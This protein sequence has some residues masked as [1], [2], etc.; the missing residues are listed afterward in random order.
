MLEQVPGLPAFVMFEMQ[1]D[2]GMI[3]KTPARDTLFKVI[4]VVEPE[5]KGLGLPP[6]RASGLQFMMDVIALCGL[7][8]GMLPGIAKAMKFTK[9][10]RTLFLET[11]KAH[12]IAVLQQQIAP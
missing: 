5:L 12:L 10:Q 2:P 4:S 7:S 8:F 6:E 1:R 11:R 9:A 3:V